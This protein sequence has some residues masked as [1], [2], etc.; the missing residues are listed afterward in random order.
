MAVP[1]VKVTSE[2]SRF[3]DVPQVSPKFV[4]TVGS[5]RTAQAMKS[6]LGV[7]RLAMAHCAQMW[8]DSRILTSIFPVP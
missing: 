8:L 7:A 1:G 2:D 5:R 3:H 4:A 6:P